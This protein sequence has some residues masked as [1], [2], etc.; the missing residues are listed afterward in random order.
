MKNAKT[1]TI[2]AAIIIVIAAIGIGVGVSL[3]DDDTNKKIELI[4]SNGKTVT[5]DSTCSRLV[6]YSKYIAEALIMMGA[7]DLVVG[8]TS[9]VLKDTNYSQYYQNAT[10]IGTSTTDGI[11]VVLTLNP[12][13]IIVQN[14]TDNTALRATG[15][16]V[17]E[18]G[19]SKMTEIVNDLTS[20]GILT[21]RTSEAKN[22]VDWYSEKLEIIDSFKGESPKFALESYS[23]TKL[24]FMAPTSTPG[25]TLHE[26]EGKNIFEDSKTSYVYPEGS[27]LIELNPDIILIVTYN[28]S[29]SEEKLAPYLNSVYDRSGWENI[30]AIQNENV[31]MVSN[32]IIGGIRSVIGGLFMISLMDPEN[33]GDISVSELVNEYN[34]LG[35]TSFNNQMVYS[36]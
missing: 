2:V 14:T 31:Y 35:N 6:V 11:D 25:V 32:D 13:A 18:L 30:S 26:V 4:D 5:L 3:G 28:A 27:T 1:V 33:Y 21:G 8:T 22:I 15:I 16:P 20:L 7:T 36:K 9:T 34:Q 19:A 24:T 29:W 12:D 17:I 10:D 23:S